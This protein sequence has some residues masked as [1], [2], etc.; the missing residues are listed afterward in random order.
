M[1]GRVDAFVAELD[2][3]PHGGTV[4]GR[5]VVAEAHPGGLKPTMQR[6]LAKRMRDDEFENWKEAQQ[7]RP[8][9]AA[10][11]V[12]V[13]DDEV[14]TSVVCP[15]PGMQIEFLGLVAH[16]LIA[17]AQ[18]RR[19]IQEG[20][21]APELNSAEQIG[22]TL[23][24][25]YLAERLRVEISTGLGWPEGVLDSDPGLVHQ[26]DDLRQA[27]NEMPSAGE[28]PLEFW[29]HWMNIARVWVMVLGRCDG[30]SGAA[31]VELNRWAQHPLIA[32]DGWSPVRGTLAEMYLAADPIRR[33][34]EARAAERV[35]R[36]IECYGQSAWVAS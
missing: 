5:L 21:I 34:V 1:R 24:D 28:P 8:V 4:D 19:S 20:W 33:H 9:A 12:F 32:D 18:R 31:D 35:A 17:L 7:G 36:P 11:K 15:L 3:H 6:E 22:S 29:S 16:E 25:E 13:A 26:T 14:V 2:R 10:G 30:G 23:F 27:L